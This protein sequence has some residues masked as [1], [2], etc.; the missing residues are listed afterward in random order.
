MRRLMRLPR[1]PVFQHGIE[2]DQH[3][4]RAGNQREF[5]GLPGGA[6]P[7]I[8][9][10]NHR[11]ETGRNDRAHVECHPHLGAPTPHRECGKKTGTFYIPDR[12]ATPLRV[13]RALLMDASLAGCLHRNAFEPAT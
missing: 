13:S 4:P 6:E 5:F 8:E 10:P 2:D 7:L 1:R 12:L 3:F 9:T 11:I